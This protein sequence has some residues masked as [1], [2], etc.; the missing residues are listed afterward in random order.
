MQRKRRDK[1][2]KVRKNISASLGYALKSPTNLKTKRRFRT[3]DAVD[4]KYIDMLQI[5]IIKF[6]NF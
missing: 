6:S 5:D 4:F 2:L 3:S 1:N